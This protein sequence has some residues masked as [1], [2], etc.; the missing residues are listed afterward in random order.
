MDFKTRLFGDDWLKISLSFLRWA[1]RASTVERSSAKTGWI[2][3]RIARN[4]PRSQCFCCQLGLVVE[5]TSDKSKEKD[6][7]H[8]FW[9]GS[10]TFTKI[11]W[12]STGKWKR[13]PHMLQI[14]FAFVTHAQDTNINGSFDP[15]AQLNPPTTVPWSCFNGCCGW[16]CGEPKSGWLDASFLVA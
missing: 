4:V 5:R 14:F 12:D 16:R 8:V 11:F 9:M 1:L 6:L 2:F 3:A 15:M 13:L 7:L 10:F